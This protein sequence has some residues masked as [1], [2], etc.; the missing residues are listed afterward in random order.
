MT[1]QQNLSIKEGDLGSGKFLVPYELNGANYDH[2]HCCS[3][4]A[5]N[6]IRRSSKS[7]GGLPAGYKAK[8]TRDC[9]SAKSFMAADSAKPKLKT[10]GKNEEVLLQRS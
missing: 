8:L 3:P 5:N 7:I 9:V 10:T 4:M 1:P 6:S 2:H